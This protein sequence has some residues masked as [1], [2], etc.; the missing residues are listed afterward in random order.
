MRFV[1]L[2]KEVEALRKELVTPILAVDMM[3]LEL[4]PP[5]KL[6]VTLRK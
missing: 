4:V 6:V 2:R 3:F 5:R 1:L